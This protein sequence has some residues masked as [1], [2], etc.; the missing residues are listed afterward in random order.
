MT[1]EEAIK[2][3]EPFIPSLNREYKRWGEK[4]MDKSQDKSWLYRDEYFER[5]SVKWGDPKRSEYLPDEIPADFL[6]GIEVEDENGTKYV[7]CNNFHGEESRRVY[8]DITDFAYYGN[9]HKYGK[10]C[11]NGLSWLN[12]ENGYHIVSN[13]FSDVEP[14]VKS[15]WNVDLFRIVDDGEMSMSD[16]K[17]GE[18]S[19]RFTYLDELIATAAYVTIIRVM[20]PVEMD[21]A[22]SY[23]TSC[24]DEDMIL[25][26]DKN[27]NVEFGE[28]LISVLKLK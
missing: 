20:G 2:I 22:G 13:R 24:K 19:G 6:V 12:K 11:I 10:L 14:R 28:K 1:R 23:A 17:P 27:D 25:T 18:A 16:C 9:T 5:P 4:L 21:N 3:L 7:S 15:I 26:I 8:L